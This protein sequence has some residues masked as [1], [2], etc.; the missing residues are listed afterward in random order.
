MN[1]TIVVEV[2]SP[3]LRPGLTMRT[4]VSERYAERAAEQMLDLARR[5]NAKQAS[6]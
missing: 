2:A 5:V 6:K 4:T 3:L 1:N